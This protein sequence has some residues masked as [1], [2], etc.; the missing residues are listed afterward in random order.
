MNAQLQARVD[1]LE[2]DLHSMKKL[3][4]SDTD[5]S[6][7]LNTELPTCESLMKKPNSPVA[8]GSFLT[9]STTPVTWTLR[10]DGSRELQL[11][12]TCRLKRY[13]SADA[14][15]CFSNRHLSFL[16]DSIT[17]YQY[18]SLVHL[19]DKG[20]YPPRFGRPD[21]REHPCKHIDELGHPTCSPWEEPNVCME[22]D[23][24]D[25]WSPFGMQLELRNDIWQFFHMSL[26]GGYDGG[27]FGG[28]FQCTCARREGQ[29]MNWT[30]PIENAL[31][32]SEEFEGG[33]RVKMSYIKE[34]G[35]GDHP[36]PVRGWNFTDCAYTGT[37]RTS[38]NDSEALFKRFLAGDVDWEDPL[39]KALNGSLRQVLPPVDIAIYN[40][41]MWGVLDKDLADTIM[42]L[43]H[44][45]V[46]E[47]RCLY[48]TAT[49][50]PVYPT[51]QLQEIKTMKEPTFNAGCGLMDFTHLTKEFGMLWYAHPAPRKQ[52][53]GTI[54]NAREWG[55]VFWDGVHYTPWVYEE[56]NNIMLNVLCNAV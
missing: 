44:D 1:K 45:F 40:R 48:R 38:R 16:G 49:A 32:V 47:G 51:D 18:L 13:T 54:S 26:G 15:Q 24:Q 4:K 53:N 17:R 50:T 3:L 33:G 56:L 14:R 12:V 36:A 29:R 9:R 6:T 35:W 20:Q 10:A 7:A 5:T 34:I 43:L 55:D 11:P 52:E 39:Y 21:R 31:Y 28:R 23:W 25:K 37:C 30:D 46:G 42:P 27:V 2:Q 22:G 8:D 19:I 41:F